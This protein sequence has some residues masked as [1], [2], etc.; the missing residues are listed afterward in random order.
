VAA[1]YLDHNVSYGWRFTLRIAGHSVETARDRHLEEAEDYDVLAIAA[2]RSWIVIT[3]NVKDFQLS[4]TAS[5][6]GTAIV[7]GRSTIRQ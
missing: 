5:W 4:L 2:A 1:F 3:H 7:T 6:S